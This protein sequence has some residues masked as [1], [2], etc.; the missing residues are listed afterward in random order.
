MSHACCKILPYCRKSCKRICLER[1]STTSGS[2]CNKNNFLL[3]KIVQ[4]LYMWKAFGRTR[5]TNWVLCEL[6][7]SV[8]LLD[9]FCNILWN[10]YL[11]S[12]FHIV[13]CKESPWLMMGKES[14][15][16][17]INMSLNVVFIL[18][19]GNARHLIIQDH[20]SHIWY[21]WNVHWIR[22][23]FIP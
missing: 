2:D 21:V 20:F 18:P 19:L 12:Y 14:R 9:S 17:A 15:Y 5:Q 6:F 8:S 23:D 1:K 10:V 11:S 7:S 4:Y 22:S 16:Y 3:N 13:L